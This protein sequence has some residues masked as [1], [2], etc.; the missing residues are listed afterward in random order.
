[1]ALM[2]QLKLGLGNENIENFEY[3]LLD[4]LY[5]IQYTSYIF[6]TYFRT[7]LII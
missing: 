3:I 1:M 4:T 5:K 2:W 6:Y 7:Y